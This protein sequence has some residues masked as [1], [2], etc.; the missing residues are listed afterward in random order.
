MR[1]CT[2]S[3][4]DDCLSEMTIEYMKQARFLEVEFEK[5]NVY[6]MD[7]DAIYWCRN[8]KVDS[9]SNPRR[10]WNKNQPRITADMYT[11]ATDMDRYPTMYV[12][13]AK[14][15]KFAIIA[16]MKFNCLVEEFQEN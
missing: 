12:R 10:R 2:N 1:K 3:K 7:E 5:V 13:I 4:E 6:N 11:N 16:E 15:L 9:S 8:I 14:T